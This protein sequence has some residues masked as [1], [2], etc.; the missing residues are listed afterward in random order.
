VNV[1]RD[2]NLVELLDATVTRVRFPN[3]TPAQE[4]RFGEIIRRYAGEADIQ[5][6]VDRLVALVAAAERERETASDI[7][8]EPPRIIFVSEPAVLV[9]YDG[10]PILRRIDTTQ[11][12]RVVNT[13]MPVARYDVDSLFYIPG[14]RTWY[15]SRSALG[16]FEMTQDVPEAM[17]NLIPR[18]VLEDLDDVDE[19]PG[20]PPRIITAKVPTELIVSD[21]PPEWEA[22]QGTRLAAMRNTDSDVI[23]NTA[24]GTY[25]V[26]LSGR[27]YAGP[28]LTGPWRHVRPDSL[29]A[30][31]AKIYPNSV[32]GDVLP[33]VAGTPQA[34][35]ALADASIPT[36]TAVNRATTTLTVTYDGAPQFETVTG[37]SV[38][39]AINSATPVL[40]V[41]T[42]YYA[43][44]EAVW[45]VSPA[46]TGPWTVSDSVPQAVASIPPS[47]P[48]HNVTYVHV[49]SST[50]E[51]VYVGYLP[52]YV[53]MYPY[54]GTVV[55]GTGYQYPP[56]VSPYAYYPRPV[57]YGM[58]VHYNPYTGWSMGVGVSVG[59]MTI[60][61]AF[62]GGYHGHYPP[63]GFYGPG[64]YRPPGGSVGRPGAGP[65]APGARP[66]TRPS[67]SIYNRPQNATR[68]APADMRARNSASG[69]PS[70][71]AGNRPSARP[72]TRPNNVYAS[73]GGDVMRRNSNGSWQQRGNSGW[74]A[75]STG[76]RASGGTMN[77]D[78]QARSRGSSRE[79]GRSSF[80]GS[81]GGGMRGGGGGRRR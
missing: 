33:F 63:G 64:G 21:G 17:M 39:Y 65:G 23:R 68:Q 20:P 59:F 24:T 31:F 18:D 51:V 4:A 71:G 2:A 77:R 61:V 53:G 49:Y 72:S 46:A 37:T 80:G 27:W 29:P 32:A 52:G 54:Y 78:Y 57:T 26:L 19:I 10:D 43:V 48:V 75:P 76:N 28:E 44:D 6:S 25:Y 12:Q 3:L 14:G 62:A 15:R 41:G 73:P 8:A 16:P 22:L 30:D 1:D 42:L 66:S 9:V 56:Y 11:V 5:V 35:E 74:Q 47:S 40:K 13:A 81:R 67:N 7:R 60:G 45:F 50:P 70:T 36:T 55:Y 69:R 58:S 34:E 38:Q 79:A